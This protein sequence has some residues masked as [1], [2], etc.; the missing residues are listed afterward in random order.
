[1]AAAKILDTIFKF[2][3]VVGEASNAVSACAQVEM[4]DAP[5]V[6]EAARRTFRDMGLNSSTT[7]TK[8]LEHH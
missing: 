7:K 6:F 2:L 3:G 8:G 4:I 1:M 5:R